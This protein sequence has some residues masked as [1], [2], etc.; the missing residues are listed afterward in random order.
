[1][2]KCCPPKVVCCYRCPMIKG[3]QGPQGA[4]G[5]QGPQGEPGTEPSIIGSQIAARWN[6][7]STIVVGM[8][9]GNID[10]FEAVLG[11]GETIVSSGTPTIF[12]PPTIATPYVQYNSTNPVKVFVS[13]EVTYFSITVAVNEI[14]ASVAIGKNGTT[15]ANSTSTSLV[16]LDGTLSAF[17]NARAIVDL[18]PGDRLTVQLFHDVGGELLSITSTSISI[19]VISDQI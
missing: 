6:N 9:V 10:T 8:P 3:P 19:T 15:L 4:T 1:M 11:V 2:L 13:G 17:G 12:A 14:G 7:S 16:G 5:P 18:N